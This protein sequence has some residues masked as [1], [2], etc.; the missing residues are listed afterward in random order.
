MSSLMSAAGLIPP[1][2]PA[3]LEQQS[4]LARGRPMKRTG[5]TLLT[6][7]GAGPQTEDK[8]ALLTA[9]LGGQV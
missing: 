6:G 2:S 5:Q 8:Q 7:G 3:V 4:L 1:K 9:R